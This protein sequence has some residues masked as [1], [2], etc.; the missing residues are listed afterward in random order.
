MLFQQ[1]TDKYIKHFIHNQLSIIV[2]FAPNQQ[3]LFVF[4]AFYI[5]INTQ[6]V[7]PAG[8]SRQSISSQ[9]AAHGKIP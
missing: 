3:T 4:N 1:T 5:Y 9:T 8:A 2:F 6:I 7:D